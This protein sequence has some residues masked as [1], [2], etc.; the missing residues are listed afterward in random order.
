MIELCLFVQGRGFGWKKFT[1][2]PLYSVEIISVYLWYLLS[3]KLMKELLKLIVLWLNYVCKC[4]FF[5]C[6]CAKWCF[7]IGYTLLFMKLSEVILIDNLKR[8]IFWIFNRLFGFKDFEGQSRTFFYGTNFF[9]TAPICQW[10]I[11]A[12]K[13]VD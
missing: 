7:T 1:N 10:H 5:A 6:F 13:K 12:H 8:S 4:I 3:S 2:C 11:G 9:C